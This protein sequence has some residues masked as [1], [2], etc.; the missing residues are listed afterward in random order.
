MGST[1]D[2]CG[3]SSKKTIA[4]RGVTR[5]PKIHKAKSNGNRI[6]VQWNAR[7]QPVKHNSKSF[8]SFVGVT[9]RRLVPISLD[10][11]SAKRNKPVVDVYK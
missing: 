2:E 8:A 10:N 5:L 7:G 4:K 11:W 9:I 1:N 6:E 3:S